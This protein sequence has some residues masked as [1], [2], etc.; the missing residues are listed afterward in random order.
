MDER[1]TPPIRI[2]HHARYNALTFGV[3]HFVQPDLS[4]TKRLG[5]IFFCLL[6]LTQAHGQASVPS[7][8]EANVQGGT[9]ANLDVD[10][11][12]AGYLHIKYYA[13]LNLAR[14]AYFQFDCTNAAVDLDK[15]A[16]F[17]LYFKN[18][19]QQR[20]QLWGLKQAYTNLD[21]HI[22]WNS[23][24]A[25]DVN[26]NS[27]LTNNPFS[28]Q[29]IGNPIMLPLSGTTPHSFTIPR[30]GDFVFGGKATVVLTGEDDPTNNAS[31]LRL[32]TNS[33][34]LSFSLTTN[35]ASSTNYDVYLI[36]GQSNMDGR[37]YNSDLT[38]TKSIWA[39]PQ[40][41]VLIYYANPVNLDATNP[42]YNTGWQ[43]LAPGF[44]VPPGF[45][46]T[47]P[48]ARF[49]P[50]ISFAKTIASQSGNHRIALIKVTQSGTSLSGDW[51]P[52]TGYMY[53]TLTNFVRIA[54]QQLRDQG[55][56]CTLRGLIWHQG[57]SDTSGSAALN[58]E[59]N[60]TE[61]IHSVRSDLGITNLPFVVGEI[62][63]NKTEVVRQAQFNVA[64]NV[65]F[66]GFASADGL[67]T[68]DGTHF[69][70]DGVLILGQRFVN[71]VEVPPLR[72]TAIT[73]TGSEVRLL[74]AGLAKSTIHLVTSPNLE[75]S[76][77]NW[78]TLLT[79]TFDA[80]GDCRFTNGITP[81]GM[82]IFY[83]LQRE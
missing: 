52:S 4:L 19:Y 21:E 41:N 68:V 67:T 65:P 83:R 32:I 48:S 29:R 70:S 69:T 6:L 56:S 25:N 7:V 14:K 3:P 47:L 31:G 11:S 80:A 23:A 5:C 35:D 18:S 77:S 54:L 20:V 60:L 72:L 74:A 45:S 28:A 76:L 17:T 62:A 63:T 1:T 42:T 8:I 46:G 71:A 36:G 38:G 39:Q 51:R 64:Q 43:T 82:N 58:Y 9:S 61:L 73:K 34:T 78:T 50:E 10:E 40:N 49:G 27:L 37:G 33:A 30:L 16:T 59:T 24:Q 57:E 13:T 44:S 12:A 53:A 22:T 66:V 79:N 55:A 15:P 81:S 75:S 26:S 2:R